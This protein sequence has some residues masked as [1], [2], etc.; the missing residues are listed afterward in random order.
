MATD[1]DS[2]AN[3]RELLYV[4][5]SKVDEIRGKLENKEIEKYLFLMDRFKNSKRSHQS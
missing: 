3:A 5:V 2:L 1:S 4:L